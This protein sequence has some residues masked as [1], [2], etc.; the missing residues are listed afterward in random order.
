LRKPEPLSPAEIRYLRKSLGWSGADFAKH[1]H[2]DPATVSRWENET[3]PMSEQND[4]LLRAM[5]ALGKRIEDYNVDT[6]AEVAKGADRAPKRL[7]LRAG[8]DGWQEASAA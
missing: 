3:Q 4:L 6:L 2:V 1:M 8:R 7:R 5:V